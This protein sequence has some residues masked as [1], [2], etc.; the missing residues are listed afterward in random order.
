[1]VEEWL[2][3]ARNHHE[4]IA[5]DRRRA[6]QALTALQ[7]TTRSPMGAIVLETGG[8]WFDHG[9]LRFLGGGGPRF[10]FDLAQF[11]GLP[12]RPGEE[13]LDGALVVAWDV[14]GGFFAINGGMFDGNKGDVYYFAPDTLQW[15]NLGVGY[16][17]LLQWAV[18]CNLDEFYS[19][20]R[21]PTWKSDIEN[22][23]GEQGL[24]FIPP[25][26]TE[27]ARLQTCC[28]HRPVPLEELW[29]SALESMEELVLVG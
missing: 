16:S 29:R 4:V 20:L 21:W 19:D 26:Y 9:W 15:D 1:M 28:Y 5:V 11:N 17:G 25:L 14:A 7:V 3:R 6:E 13:T 23:S 8:I 24:I 22:L 10:P 18:S 27:E 12:G 2:R